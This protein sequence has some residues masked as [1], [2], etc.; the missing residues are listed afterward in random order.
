MTVDI[1]LARTHRRGGGGGSDADQ[2]RWLTRI[3]AGL[4]ILVFGLVTAGTAVYG[5]ARIV[6]TQF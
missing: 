6:L 5:T 1:E 3:P 4:W 2:L